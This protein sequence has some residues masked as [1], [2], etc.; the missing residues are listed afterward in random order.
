MDGG[1]AAPASL[2]W[3]DNATTGASM[4]LTP[5]STPKEHFSSINCKILA[6]NRSVHSG[7]GNWR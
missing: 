2:Y 4:W 6:H 7:D 5:N 1:A 3:P